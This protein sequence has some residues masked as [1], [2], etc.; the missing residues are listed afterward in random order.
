MKGP[1][2]NE[3]P[4]C[5]GWK[6][7]PWYRRNKWETAHA[8]CPKC[9]MAGFTDSFAAEVERLSAVPKKKKPAKPARLFI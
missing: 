8:P 6:W 7:V 9:N 1:T 3:C 5:H 4:E 2:M